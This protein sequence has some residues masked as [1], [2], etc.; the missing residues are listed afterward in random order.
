MDLSAQG[1]TPQQASA[2]TDAVV[3]A[4]SNRKL[5]Q[6]ISSR[7]L[8]TLLGAERQKQLLG[9]C[10]SNPDA[11]ATDIGSATIARFVLSG[12]LAAVGSAFQ[13]SLQMVDTLKGQTVAR[14]TRLAGDLQTLRTLVPYAAAEATGSPLPPPPSRVVPITMIAVGGGTFF[15]GGV[16]GLLAISRQQLL[17]DELCP[18]GAAA[19]ERCGGVNLRPRDFYVQRDGELATQ[20]ALSVGLM[21]GGAALLG[22][23]L[24]LMPPAERASVAVQV[25][26]QAN[27]IAVVGSFP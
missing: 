6:V 27:G 20:K 3:S 21:I 25:L 7:D 17:N 1:A 14:S 12:Q 4:L 18:S 9:V 5:F 2:M 16:V 22:L 10:E 15:A 24:W 26:P 19:A 23:G 13:L 11:C 8:E